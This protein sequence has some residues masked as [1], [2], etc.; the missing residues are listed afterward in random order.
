MKAEIHSFPTI[1]GEGGLNGVEMGQNKDFLKKSAQKT[2]FLRDINSDQTLGG[3]VTHTF[4]GIANFSMCFEKFG[5]FSS[6]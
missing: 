4:E 2:A 3:S 1:M 6:K 5:T